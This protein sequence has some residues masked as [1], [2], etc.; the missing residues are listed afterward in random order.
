LSTEFYVY[1]VESPSSR[2]LLEGNLEGRVLCQ[3]LSL[4][5]IDSTY[6]IVAD[7]PTFREALGPR[8]VTKL[9]ADQ[10]A[11]WPIIHLSAHGCRDGI[12]LTNAD[13]FVP[14][15]DL[16]NSFRSLNLALG[17]RLMLAVSS[18]YGSFAA[19]EAL[20]PGSDPFFSLV[21]PDNEVPV[22]DLAIGFAAFYHVLSKTWDLTKAY[23]AM[24]IASH[25]SAFKLHLGENL[26]HARLQQQIREILEQ[27]SNGEPG[28]G[29][30]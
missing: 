7:T 8:L 29:N 14:W 15:S 13:H 9:Q 2:D 27:R 24:K 5:G 16:M 18:C 19:F 17:G 22:S 12:A 4:T 1:M 11:R 3:A 28:I 10:F 30:Q 6:S 26:R 25:N 21:G 20:A 23:E